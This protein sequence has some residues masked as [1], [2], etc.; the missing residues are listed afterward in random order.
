MSQFTTPWNT[1]RARTYSGVGP[2]G[3]TEPAAPAKAP[4][5]RTDHAN[6]LLGSRIGSSGHVY[7]ARNPHFAGRLVIKL[8]PYGSGLPE[9]VVG[10][11][12][13]EA[14]RVANLRHPHIA[15][16]VDW[17]VLADGTP[18]IA[19]EHLLGQTLEERIADR[20]ALPVSELLP[21]VR[22]IASAL[23]AAHAVGIVHRELRP[24]NVF[25]AN[26][27][28]Y[29]LGF[30]QL[31]DFGVSRLTAAARDAGR[32]V[33]PGTFRSLAPEQRHGAVHRADE[34]T[35]Q[36][37]LAALTYRLLTGAEP[38]PGQEAGPG[39]E[40]LRELQ[41]RPSDF[42]V[43]CAP[44]VDAV[45]CKALSR[46]PEN[47]FDSVGLFF[48]AIEE[49]LAGTSLISTPAPVVVTAPRAPLRDSRPTRDGGIERPHSPDLRAAPAT[50][51]AAAPARADS[52][53]QQFFVE[54]ERQEASQWENSPL[55]DDDVPDSPS[56]SF[57]SFDRVARRRAPLFAAALTVAAGLAV[58][59]WATG[60]GLPADK[61]ATPTATAVP[62]V[63]PPAAVAPPTVAT[64]KVAVPVV[65]AVPTPVVAAVPAPV[66]AAVPAPVVAAIVAPIPVAVSAKILPPPPQPMSRGR[67]AA[68]HTQRRVAP[69]RGYVWSPDQR[70]LTP[71]RFAPPP[72]E[73]PL[74]PPLTASP[75]SSAAP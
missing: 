68:T 48:R 27:A 56:Q 54:G 6:Y 26:L 42:F 65:V 55:V 34:R 69:L 32:I 72:S 2:I 5:T 45:L 33:G 67:S 7:E 63:A 52:L 58:A 29:D 35:D 60:W 75:P 73:S 38:F 11:F 61:Q 50:D 1:D 37:A 23:S 21:V 74:P 44:A 24:D 18:F 41:A 49:A 47:R 40:R 10:A 43:R 31:L 51:R 39:F 4:P 59:A 14:S 66:V 46:R 17:G 22:G 36:F 3:S 20:G 9:A 53:T 13:R 15:Q 19:L 70:R 57:A 71:A 64:P 62:A 25:I 16:V 28:G 12:T 30:A 8:F